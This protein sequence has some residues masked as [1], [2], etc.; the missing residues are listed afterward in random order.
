MIEL[1]YYLSMNWDFDVS[2]VL[3]V[4]YGQNIDIEKKCFM[5]KK[6]DHFPK[7]CTMAEGSAFLLNSTESTIWRR[8]GALY[9]NP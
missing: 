5:N 7:Q 1:Q 6:I 9:R 8:N 2:E 3:S 4:E